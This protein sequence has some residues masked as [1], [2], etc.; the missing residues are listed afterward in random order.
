[1]TRQE[2]IRY[3]VAFLFFVAAASVVAFLYVSAK[4]ATYHAPP[5]DFKF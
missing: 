3:C 2:L 5:V 4:K 1:M